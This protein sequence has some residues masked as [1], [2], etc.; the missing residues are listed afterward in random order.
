[1]LLKAKSVNN[2]LL[3]VC[4]LIYLLMLYIHIGLFDCVTCKGRRCKRISIKCL[5]TLK[6][7]ELLGSKTWYGLIYYSLMQHLVSADFE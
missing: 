1:M 3:Y 7:I 4:L 6:I 2:I 5:N